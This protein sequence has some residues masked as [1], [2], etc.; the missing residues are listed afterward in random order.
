VIAIVIA[1]PTFQQGLPIT[2]RRAAPIH[3]RVNGSGGWYDTTRP[4]T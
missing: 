1:A 2:P 3:V 4:V